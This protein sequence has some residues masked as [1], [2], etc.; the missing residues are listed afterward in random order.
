MVGIYVKDKGESKMNNLKFD[1]QK[2]CGK[3]KILHA[4]NNISPGRCRAAYKEAKIPYARYHDTG[5]WPG[6]G[7]THVVDITGVFPD[8]SKDVNDPESYDFFFTDKYVKL[9]FDAGAEPFYRLGESIEHAP[10]KYRILTPPDAEKWAEI[11]EHIIMHY[12]EGWAD[13]FNYNI[14]YWEI[15]N[16]P[17]CKD[18]SMWLGTQQEFF[19]LYEAAATRI[20]KRFPHI[21]IGGPAISQSAFGDLEWAGQFIEYMA[22]K[23][24]PM[25]FFSWH[26]YTNSTDET[27]RIATEI[28]EMLDK[29][30]LTE[31]ESILNE[32][33]YIKGWKEEFEY[34]LRQIK[35]IKGAAFEGAMI[36]TCQNTPVDMLMYYDARPSGFNG[37][38]DSYVSD[39]LKGYYPIKMYSKLYELGT[40]V[41]CQSDTK[42]V[43]GL[44]AKNEKGDA[45]FMIARYEDDDNIT[46]EKKVTISFKGLE[47]KTLKC[48]LVDNET[49][50]YIDDV[51]TD[52]SGNLELSLKPNC[53]YLLES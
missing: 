38:F 40:Q 32:W 21:K 46:E 12:T 16:E 1:F 35:G 39:L 44:G 6:M 48:F 43:Y 9:T 22:K 36:C 29:N 34:S 3:M 8:F 53:C 30:G 47:N 37:M 4:V 13:G 20:K 41:E 25:D 2:E 15:W 42:D 24:V 17:D 10:K 31:T 49:N 51:T 33:N 14:E 19:D 52:A 18:Q 26:I 11:C 7:G 5:L 45:A 28:R 50:D 23:N 27:V